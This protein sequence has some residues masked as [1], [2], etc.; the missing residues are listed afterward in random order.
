M[1]D[2]IKNGKHLLMSYLPE[3]GSNDQ[4]NCLGK[5]GD[6]KLIILTQFESSVT[7]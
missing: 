5:A 7:P 4:L 2:F 6:E 3:I 1:I